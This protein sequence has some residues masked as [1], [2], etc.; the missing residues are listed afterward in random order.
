MGCC[1]GEG[2]VSSFALAL[3][4]GLCFSRVYINC[5]TMYTVYTCHFMFVSIFPS[6]QEISGVIKF[7][8]VDINLHCCKPPKI[9]SY[10]DYIHS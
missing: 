9:T 3:I 1:S 10:S 5:V 7:E 8:M 6:D 4:G 2:N